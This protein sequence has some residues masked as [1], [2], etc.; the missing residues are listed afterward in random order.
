M[1]SRGLHGT[2]RKVVAAV[3]VLVAAGA[4]VGTWTL[5]RSD[6]T[7][8]DPTTTL[9]A[10]TSGTVRQTVTAT[11][12][13]EPARQ[14]VLSFT[15][16][17]TVTSVPATVGQAVTAGQAL[18]TVGTASL[19]AAVTT[20]QAS[21][22]AAQG[23][24]TAQVA[25]SG[26]ATQLASAR[27]QLASAQSRLADA[28]AALTAGTLTSTI[29]GTVAAVSVA[30]GDRVAGSGTGGG[31]GAA[32]SS[33]T[34]AAATDTVTVIST[35][36]DV[37]DAAVGSSDLAQVKKGLQAEIT[38]TGAAQRVF[39]TVSSVG[40]VASTSTSA[41]GTASAATFPVTIAVTG[42]PTGLYAGGTASVVVVVRQTPDVLTVP[43]L[44]LHTAGTQT[45]V[46]Q[47]RGGKQVSIP[48]TVGRSFGPT[49][50]ITK[51]IAAGDQV[52]VT[53]GR[54]GAG[55]GAARTRTGGAGGAGGA[56]GFGGGAGGFGGG[57]PGG[58]PPAG[59]GGPG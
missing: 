26:S 58:A 14:A 59:A 36:A 39:G 50:Q 42:T 38:P 31:Q 21:L 23:A 27:A 25:A 18:A 56:G 2:R 7:A 8:A 11:G 47:R 37:V 34:A 44:A 33:S 28:Q 9:V 3:V 20:A 1:A 22:T 15:V 45:V 19:A 24:V 6:A 16:A 49:T 51:G 57:F 54:P 48:V 17:G 10:A 32:G 46:Y 53:L 4:A 35:D 52:V 55:T 30:V 29:D 41:G 12:T 5:T 13:I 40:I 43:T